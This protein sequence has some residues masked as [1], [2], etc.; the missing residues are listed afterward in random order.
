MSD[1]LTRLVIEHD[2][3]REKQMK[4]QA[5]LS[6]ENFSKVDASQ[7]ILLKIQVSAMETYRAILEER[8]TLLS[9]QQSN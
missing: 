3:L 8:I 7:Q 2:E 4:L 5:F 9:P 6:T 1:F